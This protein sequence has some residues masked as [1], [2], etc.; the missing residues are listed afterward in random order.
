MELHEKLLALRKSNGMTQDDLAKALYVSRQ[1]VYKWESGRALPDIE[2]LKQLC[3]L[4]QVSADDLLNINTNK[5]TGSASF[6]QPITENTISAD[7]SIKMKKRSLPKCVFL[8]CLILLSVIGAIVI[9]NWK[10][11]EVREAIALGVVPAELQSNL[12][13]T[14]SERD[15]LYMLKEIS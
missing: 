4:F 14:V 9:S 8:L 3:E 12:G 15:F 7:T 5:Q 13:D 11:A 1:S 2:K 10:S 6:Q